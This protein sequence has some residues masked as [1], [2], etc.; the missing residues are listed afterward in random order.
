G[1]E[2]QGENNQ[3]GENQGEENQGEE[4]QGEENQGGENPSTPVSE[5]TPNSGVKVWS[6]NH[7]IYIENAA[8]TKYKIIDLQG[9]TIT[10]STAKS[11]REEVVVTNR[12]N[13]IAI[14]II[15]GKS[16]KLKI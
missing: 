7:T 10:T 14:V 11:D 1:G 13:S 5:I 6:Y 12:N 8:D 2:N 16:F 15:N 4:D 3:G 9:R